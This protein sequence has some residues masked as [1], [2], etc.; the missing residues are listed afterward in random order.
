MRE[1]VEGARGSDRAG[2]E[3]MQIC[4]GVGVARTSRIA[5]TGVSYQPTTN[6][7]CTFVDLMLQR[8][9]VYGSGRPG[10]THER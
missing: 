3:R 7:R 10:R 5:M 2:R 8:A 6:A 4:E 9:Y 1:E